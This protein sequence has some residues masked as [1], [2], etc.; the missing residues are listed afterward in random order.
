MASTKEIVV[1]TAGV[2]DALADC[3]SVVF[4][5]V[6]VDAA[7]LVV[8]VA[9]LRDVM[10]GLRF[11]VTFVG[12]TGFLV[13]FITVDVAVFDGFCVTGRLVGLTEVAT[14]SDATDVR[15]NACDETGFL[16]EFV[17][18]VLFGFFVL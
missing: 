6:D 2:V 15:L 3:C 14:S 17:G 9:F 10:I 13:D 8:S 1:K 16:V 18:F 11:T 4:I 12:A 5:V 7:F